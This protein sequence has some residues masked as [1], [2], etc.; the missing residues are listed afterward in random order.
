VK[1]ELIPVAIEQLGEWEDEWRALELSSG[2]TNVYLAYDWLRAWAEV[3]RPRRLLLARALKA[4]DGGTA[5]L[6]LIEIDR[7]KGWHFAGGSS[8]ACRA[9]LCAVGSEQVV[10]KAL[11]DWLHAHP[12]AWSTLDA[13][14]VGQAAELAP[15]AQLQIRYS[16]CLS[17]PDSFDAYLMSLTS[18]QRN[19]F[20]K[21]LRRG[22]EEGVTVQ[23]VPTH[24][25]DGAIS[26]FLH[27]HRIRA[28]AKGERHAN[29]DERLGQLLSKIAACSTIE[30]SL[31]DLHYEGRRVAVNVRLGYGGVLFPYNLG[32]DPAAAHL[33]P[34]ILLA[35]GAVAD[36]LE[37]GVRTIDLGPGEQD[38]KLAL[39]CVPQARLTLHASNA[40]LWGRGLRAT[41]S[42]YRRLR[43]PSPRPARASL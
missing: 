3:Y 14:E 36:A 28:S 35:L 9:P 27:L 7:I 13:S 42:A 24:K 20:R 31:F 4:G 43:A 8:S 33:A 12:R 40:S 23:R 17:L 37:Q 11:A 16:A 18:K 2:N 39:G 41:G 38:Y 32:W 26:D 21:R 5:M 15:G 19:T 34:G 22:E 6:G 1:L 25:R 10:W 30:L 29:V